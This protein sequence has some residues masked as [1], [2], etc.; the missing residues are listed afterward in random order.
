MQVAAVRVFVLDLGGA[1]TFFGNVARFAPHRRRSGSTPPA[2]VNNLV[3][4]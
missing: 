3:L 4:D 1:S 2:L